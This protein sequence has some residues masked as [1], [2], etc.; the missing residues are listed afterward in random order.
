MYYLWMTS[1]NLLVIGTRSSLKTETVRVYKLWELLY[2]NSKYNFVQCYEQTSSDQWVR[3]LAKMM[4]SEAIVQDFGN[5]HPYG[6]KKEAFE[7]SGSADFDSLNG[8]K[9][10][11]I[12]L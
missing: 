7:K 8:V 4:T 12:A 9:M 3:N 2:A 6:Q 1:L 5:L 11:A 10:Q